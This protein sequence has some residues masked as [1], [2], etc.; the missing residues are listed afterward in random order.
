LIDFIDPN[1]YSTIEAALPDRARYALNVPSE[2]NQSFR[3]PLSRWWLIW[4]LLILLP[5]IPI[6][7]WR[8]D[9]FQDHPSLETGWV[10]FSPLLVIFWIAPAFYRLGTAQ[11]VTVRDDGIQFQ[12][13]FFSK[14]GPAERVTSVT[15]DPIAFHLY[16]EKDKITLSKKRVPIELAQGLNEHIAAHK[17]ANRPT[18]ASPITPRVD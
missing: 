13:A 9:D 4:P 10:L 8:Y 15:K 11:I 17:E 12:R 3:I 7:F 5:L 16:S 1:P 14:A 18:L 2:M 6:I